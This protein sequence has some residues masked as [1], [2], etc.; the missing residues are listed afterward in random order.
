M[1]AVGRVSGRAGIGC[2]QG[3][4]CRKWRLSNLFSKGQNALY[5]CWHS[6]CRSLVLWQFHDSGTM[7]LP[8]AFFY[9]MAAVYPSLVE[10]L[11]VDCGQQCR[12]FGRSLS[13]NCCSESNA[14]TVYCPDVA[15]PCSAN[16][17]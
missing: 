3:F 8:G 10:K 4:A 1:V 9:G 5:R 16:P 14:A 12:D 7:V 6:A 15:M 11:A 13:P 17:R 2:V